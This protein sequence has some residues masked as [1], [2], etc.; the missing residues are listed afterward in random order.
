MSLPVVY[1]VHGAGATRISFN[2]MISVLPKHD[3]RFFDYHTDE[4]LN[5]CVTRLSETIAAGPPCVVVGHSLGGVIAAAMAPLPSVRGVV[6]VCAPFAGLPSATLLA[7]LRPNQLFRDVS[8]LNP[9]LRRIRNGVV[10]HKK[11]HLP[12]VGDYGLPLC[13]ADNDGVVPVESQVAIPGLTYRKFNLN[14]FEV[15]L[16]GEVSLAIDAFLKEIWTQ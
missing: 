12:I 11:P 10:E 9:R 6:T 13:G 1:Y 4:G 5:S 16:S 15:L 2:W 7:M 3:A 14:H 8:S